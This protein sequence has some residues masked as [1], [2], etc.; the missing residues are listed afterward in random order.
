MSI[1]GKYQRILENYDA[2]GHQSTSSHFQGTKVKGAFGVDMQQLNFVQKV[3]AY[4][5]SLFGAGE[6]VNIKDKV[7]YV[8]IQSRDAFLKR[9]NEENSEKETQF[10]GTTLQQFIDSREEFKYDVYETMQI[11]QTTYDQE[12]TEIVYKGESEKINHILERIKNEPNQQL[13][14]AEDRKALDNEFDYSK[15]PIHRLQ[16]NLQVTYGEFKK[17]LEE[18]NKIFEKDKTQAIDSLNVETLAK[19]LD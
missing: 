19:Y 1:E 14:S 9:Y 4:F 18:Q 6:V 11:G 16:D 10:T 17:T 12:D 7:Y 13:L 8:P 5:R 3:G 2:K 15:G